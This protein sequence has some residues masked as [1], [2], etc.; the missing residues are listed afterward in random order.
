VYPPRSATHRGLLA[1][2]DWL[3]RQA[4]EHAAHMDQAMPAVALAHA[5]KPD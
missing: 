2:R 4:S 3:H 5:G 1:F